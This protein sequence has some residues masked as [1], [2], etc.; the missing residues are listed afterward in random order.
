MTS[1]LIIPQ[2]AAT[3]TPGEVGAYLRAAGWE[4]C[5]VNERWVEFRRVLGDEEATVEVPQRLLAPDYPRVV[6]RV[7]DYLA[8][9]E[10]RPVAMVHQDVLSTSTDRVRLRLVGPGII[11]GRLSLEAGWQVYEAARD[12]MLAA[13]CA[14]RRTAAAFPRRKAGESMAVLN[15]ARFGLAEAGSFVLNIESEV[16]GILQGSLVDDDED[17]SA[18][19]ERKAAVVLARAL[20]AAQVASHDALARGSLGA[21]KAHVADGVSANLCEALADMITAADATSLDTSVAFASRRP[22]AASVPRSASFTAEARDVLRDAAKDLRQEASYRAV[23]VAGLVRRLDSGDVDCGGVVVLQGSVDGRARP[24]HVE[25]AASDY[26][27]A[28]DAHR[29]GVMV[30]CVGDLERSGRSWVLRSPRHF[31]IIADPDDA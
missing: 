12:L 24:I 18:P 2:R 5:D 31:G 6:M 10:A 17:L 15:H 22:V 9:L 8:E 14:A 19:L 1:D 28:V 23:D 13:A 20:Q 16:A 27:I 3:P 4:A 29:R 26:K 25:L 21:F 30:E 11:A 7:L